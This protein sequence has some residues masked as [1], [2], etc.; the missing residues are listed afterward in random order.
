MSF[1]PRVAM[2]KNS[3]GTNFER[4]RINLIE[5]TGVTLTFVDSSAN[6]EIQVT[7]AASGASPGSVA[8]AIDIGD[9]ASDGVSANYARADHQHQ[10]AAPGASYVTAVRRNT[11]NA[12]GTATTPARSDHV[13]GYSSA[14][15]DS[16]VQLSRLDQMAAPTASVSLNSQKIINLADPTSA[17]DAATKAYVDATAA[18]I[19]WKGSVRAATTGSNIT[20]AGGAPNTLDGVSLAANDRILV[21]DQSTGSQNGIYIVQTLGTGANGTWVRASD[22]DTSAEVTAGVAV[23]VEEGTT[24]GDTG[25]VLT[26]NNPITLSTTSLTFTQFTSLGQITAGAGLTKTGSTIDVVAA[27]ASITVNADSIQVGYGTPSGAIDIGD[28]N[29]AGSAATAARSD[30]QH[31]FTAPGASYPQPVAAALADGTA[32]TPARSDH[33]H[34]H[35]TA[36]RGGH[37]R[38]IVSK[39]ANYTAVTTDDVILTDATSGAFTITLYAASGNTG[40]VLTIKKTDSGTNGVT[41]DAN[42]S[43]LIDGQTTYIL[44]NQYD[45]IDILCDGT[46]WQIV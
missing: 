36:Y 42:A 40:K 14:N 21:K 44:T 45:S 8:G 26:T 23:F 28:T 13:H 38:T 22:A 10:F 2:R 24:N 7:I 41:V 1:L 29:T 34:A 5:G 17:Q 35:G 32:T 25:W 18:G 43:E 39:T 15:F 11:A 31:A 37:T 46:G 6:D 9:A 12:D 27:D 3:A 4:K 20:L 16:D 19:D 33:V 30:H